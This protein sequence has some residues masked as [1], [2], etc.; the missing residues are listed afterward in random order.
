MFLVGKLAIILQHQV[1]HS[2]VSRHNHLELAGNRVGIHV[3]ITNDIFL[4]LPLARRQ[5]ADIFTRQAGG[6]VPVNITHDAERKLFRVRET[7]PIKR[8]HPLEIHLVKISRSPIS[9]TIVNTSRQLPNRI[10]NQIL[11]GLT[12]ILVHVFSTFHVLV[13]LRSLETGFLEHQVI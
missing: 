11:W 7:F 10:L 5:R 2:L 8:L 1:H 3:V 4:L 13:K 9:V 12:T 6:L